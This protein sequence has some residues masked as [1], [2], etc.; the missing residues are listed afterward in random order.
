M[1]GK[2]YAS[3]SI[4]NRKNGLYIFY[5]ENATASSNGIETEKTSFP[6]SGNEFYFDIKVDKGGICHFSFAGKDEK[7]ISIPGTFTM[8]PG[9]WVGAKLGIFMLSTNKTNDAGFS[10]IDWLRFE[11]TPKK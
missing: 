1:L 7:F 4:E 5:S 2:S 6:V 9:H 8:K 10:D 3:I 11:L